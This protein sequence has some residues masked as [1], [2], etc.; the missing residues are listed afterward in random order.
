MV[1]GLNIIIFSTIA[2]LAHKEKLA[3]KRSNQLPA[4]PESSE[5]Q[6]PTETQFEKDGSALKVLAVAPQA[7]ET[8]GKPF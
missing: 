1:A 7:V 2:F 5:P 4:T 3:K 6:T 8:L